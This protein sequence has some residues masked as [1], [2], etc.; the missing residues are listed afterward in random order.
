MQPSLIKNSL[1]LILVSVVGFYSTKYFIDNYSKSVH[2][3]TLSLNTINDKVL[4]DS[5]GNGLKIGELINKSEKQGFIIILSSTICQNCIDDIPIWNSLYTKY[6]SEFDFIGLINNSDPYLFKDL[7][8]MG[9]FNFPVYQID[10]QT[11]TEFNIVSI[12]T[13]FVLDKGIPQ[14]KIY[15]KYSIAEFKY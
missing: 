7:L 13:Y 6:G 14:P 4:I 11:F 8:E 9:K 10:R 12:P 3:Q 2:P 1:L 5:S 15:D